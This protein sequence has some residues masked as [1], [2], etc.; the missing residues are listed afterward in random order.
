MWSPTAATLIHGDRDAIL[1]DPLMTQSEGEDLAGWIAATGKNLTTVFVTHG[2]GDHFFGAA[3]ILN[4]FRTPTWWHCPQ[5]S[6]V[7]WNSA[8][9]VKAS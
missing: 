6:G 3:P 4:R 5:W 1:V 7:L 8:H 2:H 9:A